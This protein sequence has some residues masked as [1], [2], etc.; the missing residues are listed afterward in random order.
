M[1]SLHRSRIGLPQFDALARA[2][3]YLKQVPLGFALGLI[4][5]QAAIISFDSLAA[6]CLGCYGNDWIETPNWDRLAATG[7]VFDRHFA[8]TIGPLAGMAWADGQQA[9]SPQDGL[10]TIPVGSR[11]KSNGIATR[12]ITAVEERSWQRGAEFDQTQTVHGRD[13]FDA[14]PDEIP[15]AQVVKAG[16][17]EWSDAS[18]QQRPRLLWLHSPG[19]GRPP[20]GFDSLYFEDFEERGEKIAELSNEERSEHPAV[21]AGAVSLL[22][23][24]LGELL[25]GIESHTEPM[26]I[27]VMAAQGYRWHRIRSSK[28]KETNR[29]ERLLDDQL[30]RTPLLLNVIG[31]D[32]FK[33]IGSLRSD[34]LVQTCDLIPTLI[35]WF[36]LTSASD[37]QS[38]GGQSWLRELTEEAV[39]RQSL[40]IGDKAGFDAIRTVDWLCIRDNT[41]KS[42]ADAPT[43]PNP[44]VS[45][46]AKPEDIWDVDDIAS[47]QPEI[48]GELLGR[49][50]HDR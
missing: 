10:A 23:H 41:R 15:F 36:E 38:P 1:F 31:D 13:G 6:N 40:H 37:E 19:P 7:A 22:D 30:I 18:F 28:I 14:Q 12:F 4:A 45:L 11:L 50:P 16:L 24:W 34:R 29:S 44:S 35:D 47:Q 26:L 48:V 49:I 5:M 32:R 43:P 21:Y 33:D 25:T 9:H 17:S 3:G 27:V 2:L 39:P 8:E 42:E 46:F 20:K